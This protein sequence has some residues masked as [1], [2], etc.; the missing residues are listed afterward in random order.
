MAVTCRRRRVRSCL[1]W[2]NPSQTNVMSC[3]TSWSSVVLA[4]N[5]SISW[6]NC[7]AFT[8]SALCSDNVDSDGCLATAAAAAAGVLRSVNRIHRPCW[9]QTSSYIIIIIIIIINEIQLTWRK[10]ENYKVT[11]QRKESRVLDMHHIPDITCEW[12]NWTH[13]A[14]SWMLLVLLSFSRPIISVTFTVQQYITAG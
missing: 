9:E 3:K 1:L 12:M 8:V 13:V 10:V 6:M 5:W 11:L 7:E 4:R 14:S 2:T